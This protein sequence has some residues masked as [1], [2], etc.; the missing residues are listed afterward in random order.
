M[1]RDWF[2][3]LPFFYCLT[4][5]VFGLGAV[6][7]RRC[8]K[9]S[10]AER[11]VI[12]GLCVGFALLMTNAFPPP[13]IGSVLACKHFLGE[14]A[15][16]KRSWSLQNNSPTHSVPTEADLAVFFKGSVLP[17]CPTGG[18]YSFGAVNEPPRCSRRGHKLE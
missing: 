6:I 15:K 2:I 4:V 13:H 18:T 5:I 7:A 9:P 17:H 14:I 10:L 11:L 12:A 1:S 8:G 16:A 3:F